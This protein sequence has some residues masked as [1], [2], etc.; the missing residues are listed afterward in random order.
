MIRIKWSGLRVSNSNVF[1]SEQ[2]KRWQVLLLL[3]PSVNKTHLTWTGVG[4]GTGTGTGTKR[5][6]NKVQY[7]I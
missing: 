2:L 5:K 1:S 6:G 4:T 7:N 3:F